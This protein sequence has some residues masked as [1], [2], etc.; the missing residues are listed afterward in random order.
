[1]LNISFFHLPISPAFLPSHDRAAAV[2]LSLD[3]TPARLLTR[4]CR[5]PEFQQ[6]VFTFAQG[7][8]RKLSCD[9]KCGGVQ[10]VSKVLSYQTEEAAAAAGVYSIL[11]LSVDFFSVFF[12]H[13][14]RV[15]VRSTVLLQDCCFTVDFCFVF[16]IFCF[17]ERSDPLCCSYRVVSY[18]W[19]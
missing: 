15:A 13:H 14:H 9:L 3:H 10:S 19:L 16:E 8:E 1:M 12:T 2:V 6:S 7:C 5:S 18:F 4:R 11:R 17:F